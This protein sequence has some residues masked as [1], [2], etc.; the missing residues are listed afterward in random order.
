MKNTLRH[1]YAGVAVIWFTVAITVVGEFSSSFKDILKNL[2]GHHWVTKGILAVALY[3]LI[4]SVA[5][6]AK[7]DKEKQIARGVN[8]LIW[9]TIIA[10]L[11][12]LIFFMWHFL[13]E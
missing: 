6:S 3:G 13:T 5:P 7:K 9:N 8:I 11:F 1:I 10:T 2:T 4:V 12:F